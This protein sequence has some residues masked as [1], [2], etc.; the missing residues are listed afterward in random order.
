VKGA[1]SVPK[2]TKPSKEGLVMCTTEKVFLFI[3]GKFHSVYDAPDGK[4]ILFTKMYEAFKPLVPVGEDEVSWLHSNTNMFSFK[5]INEH[6][7]ER[8]LDSVQENQIN[9]F[10]D[11]IIVFDGKTVKNAIETC[12]LY[13]AS[14]N[15][16][17]YANMSTIQCGE[18][19]ALGLIE[20][21]IYIDS[22]LGHYSGS[23]LPFAK[24]LVKFYEHYNMLRHINASDFATSRI[25]RPRNAFLEI[26]KED[27][28][29]QPVIIDTK[30]TVKY[31]SPKA[32]HAVTGDVKLTK[33]EENEG[34][35][36]SRANRWTMPKEMRID[37]IMMGV[38]SV[39]DIPIWVDDTIR[40]ACTDGKEIWANSE[41]I[42]KPEWWL[43][44]LHEFA[45]IV[46]RHTDKKKYEEE[47]GVDPK[48][49]KCAKLNHSLFNIATDIFINECIKRETKKTIE[50][51]LYATMNLEGEQV[52]VP[53]QT[54]WAGSVSIYKY[55]IQ[56]L[57]QQPGSDGDQ[58]AGYEHDDLSNEIT[59][60]EAQ[61]GSGQQQGKNPLDKNGQRGAWEGDQDADTDEQPGGR[62]PG[63][64]VG[65]KLT[66]KE[67]KIYGIEPVKK[68]QL[69]KFMEMGIKNF[70]TK[71][72]K[73]TYNAYNR[74]GIACLPGRR[75]HNV[76]KNMYVY[77]DNSGS[78]SGL[79]DAYYNTALEV[80]KRLKKDVDMAYEF[81]FNG[82]NH[83]GKG[84]CV[85]GFAKSCCGGTDFDQIFVGKDPK[86]DTVIVI[87]DGEAHFGKWLEFVAHGGQ[88]LCYT[89]GRAPHDMPGQVIEI[90][91]EL[92]NAA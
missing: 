8:I 36:R 33:K 45:H 7:N 86:K 52:C 58:Y 27:I 92:V 40:T 81:S 50:G 35:Q 18:V 72:A 67:M 32:I 66:D 54:V 26:A 87:T 37:F 30:G 42:A 34:F 62:R 24:S 25:N 68:H 23:K 75:Q 60:E 48:T 22:L 11:P 71:N 10:L 20:P 55:L 70:T 64:G 57:P 47:F 6:S 46:F 9:T 4:N 80:V 83:D 21:H 84:S 41:F 5:R 19:F 82:I 28:N 17:S 59:N 73:R 3:D 14:D 2:K 13:S 43:I 78:M 56:T 90:P 61:A 38:L 15:H 16:K 88:T 91:K 29:G 65:E 39:L 31:Y 49:G 79:Y 53:M 85:R 76:C 77:L 44:I 1:G 51:G 63:L 74:R 89:I 69:G 12:A